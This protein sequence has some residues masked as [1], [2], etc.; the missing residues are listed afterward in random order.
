MI[1][2][3]LL[4]VLIGLWHAMDID[5]IAAI[6]TFIA[7]D[8]S[9]RLRS[10][11][12]GLIWGLGHATMLMIVALA[13]MTFNLQI[14]DELAWLME[15]LVAVMLVVLALDLFRRLAKI[16][17]HTHKHQHHT[18]A[19]HTHVHVHMEN[20][21]HA[22]ERHAHHHY[23]GYFGRALLVGLMHGSAGSAAL[24][25]LVL[26]TISS[27][28][29]GIVYVVMFG[30]G[31]MLGMTLLTAIISAQLHRSRLRSAKWVRVLRR[32]A[33]T[34]TL[35]VGLFLMFKAGASAGLFKMI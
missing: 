20:I 3:L 32:S 26:Q 12:Y 1:E 22:P 34:V 35:S 33:A 13:V 18:E 15:F 30:V 24:V 2:I 17:V 4:G 28:A 5:H 27:R 19:I 10:V 6:I 9:S 8:N 29:L 23:K 21:A 11:V 14:G 25:L 31:S 16:E 7:V